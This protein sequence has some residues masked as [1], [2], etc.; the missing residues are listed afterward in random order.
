MATTATSPIIL[1]TSFPINVDATVMLVLALTKYMN[2]ITTLATKVV[3]F[4]CC[5]IYTLSACEEDGCPARRIKKRTVSD[6]YTHRTKHADFQESSGRKPY[7]LS[8]AP[9]A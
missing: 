6:W 8:S 1:G 3:A 2:V 4:R 9:F 7:M 5:M